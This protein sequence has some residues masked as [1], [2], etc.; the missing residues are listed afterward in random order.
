MIATIYCPEIFTI[1]SWADTY[2]GKGTLEAVKC[3]LNALEEKE[4]EFFFLLFF[5][6][7]FNSPR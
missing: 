3:H 1:T 4:S 7:S 5:L 2:F 6:F